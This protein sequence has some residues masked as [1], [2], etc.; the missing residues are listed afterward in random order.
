MTDNQIVARRRGRG[1]SQRSLDLIDA[2]KTILE[3]IRPATIRAICYQLFV[4]KLLMGMVKSETHRAS[5]QLTWAREHGII[6]WAWIV[7][8]TRKVERVNAFE[9]PDDYVQV[10]KHAYR[11]DRWTDQPKRVEVWS[12]R[13][14]IAGTL[15]RFSDAY[16]VGFRVMHGFGS[17]TQ[18]HDIAVESRA[19][20]KRLTA[21]YVGDW[22]LRPAHVRGGP[23]GTAGGIRRRRRRDADR[24][25]RGRYA[26]LAIVPGVDEGTDQDVEGRSALPWFADHYGPSCW[27]LDALSPAILRD[28]KSRPTSSGCW[29]WPPGTVPV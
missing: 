9:N 29:T 10:V 21:L 27:E 28:C 16:G 3:A 4:M 19:S 8:D 6:P 23:A 11:R 12:E 24:L 1:K 14:T 20:K 26:H 7:D 25:G 17:T 18:L 5:S 2:A 13:G 15:R 22:D